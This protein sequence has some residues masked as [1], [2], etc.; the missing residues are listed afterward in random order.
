MTHLFSF[1]QRQRRE[2]AAGADPKKFGPTW[3]A[4]SNRYGR[5]HTAKKRV[6]T[7]YKNSYLKLIFFKQ[8]A[9][10]EKLNF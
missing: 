1:Q 4:L 2:A 5:T 3:M 10:I 8:S 6:S 9:K 7:R